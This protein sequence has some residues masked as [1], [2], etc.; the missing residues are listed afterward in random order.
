MIRDEVSTWDGIDRDYVASSLLRILDKYP[1]E[2]SVLRAPLKL[3]GV[4]STTP[5]ISISVCQTCGGWTTIQL[6]KMTKMGG[7]YRI[8]PEALKALRCVVTTG[9]PGPVEVAFPATFEGNP[10]KE[11]VMNNTKGVD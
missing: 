6:R 4:R 9:C 3:K 5:C 10:T 8:T 1:L 11:E 7:V 2:L